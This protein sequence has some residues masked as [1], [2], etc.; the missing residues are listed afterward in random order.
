M[1]SP[2]AEA[3]RCRPGA[4]PALALLFLVCA[5]AALLQPY[6]V[7]WPGER[8]NLFTPLLALLPL[9]PLWRDVLGQ[10]GRRH[11]LAWAVLGAGLAASAWV[12]AEPGPSLARA[13]AFWAPAASGLF[14]AASLL[15]PANARRA[16]FRILTACFAAV[17]AM[18]FA[19]GSPPEF[20]G[21]HHHA[22]TGVLLLLS[23]GPIHWLL[24]ARGRGRLAPAALLAA[25][26]ALCFLAGSRFAVL[27]PVLVFSGLALTGRRARLRSLAVAAVV[28]ALALVFFE[29]NPGKL[30][31][32][33]NY[34]STSYR[35]EGMPAAVELM[36][37][38]PVAGI[39]IRTART[40]MLKDFVP[41]FGTADKTF[42]L[43]VLSRNVTLDNQYLSLP[44]GVGIPLALL[45]FSLV[46]RLL[47][48]FGR[49]V[50]AR[51][52][53]AATEMALLVPLAGTALHLVI[54]DGL[55]YPQ[56]SWFF[57]LLLGFAACLSARGGDQVS[58][59]P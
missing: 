56:I 7:L 49:A 57:H 8:T 34:E 11:W 58:G 30:L 41:V 54:Y 20:L 24:S 59:R 31:R 38:H 18:H 23:A 50:A 4:L 43:D 16:L 6:L 46:G 33:N 22:L 32:F 12:S 25:G 5:Q 28:A 9:V 2:H 55:F 21:W 15:G 14:C 53:D 3:G 35:L 45:Y 47:L 51:R 29:V 10:W 26:Y 44:V 42:F 1:N 39:G 37:Q 19:L 48:R 27:L 17:T 40:E 13:F 52:L 36:R